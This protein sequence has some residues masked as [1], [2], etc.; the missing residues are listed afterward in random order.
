MLVYSIFYSLGLIF[1]NIALWL[2]LWGMCSNNVIIPWMCNI[3]L[4]FWIEHWF[5]PRTITFQFCSLQV[6]PLLSSPSSTIW[7]T[8]NILL[9]NFQYWKNSDI[10]LCSQYQT[11]QTLRKGYIFCSSVSLCWSAA[12]VRPHWPNQETKLSHSWLG[13]LGDYKSE[14]FSFLLSHRCFWKKLIS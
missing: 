8:E 2:S 9:F 13:A 10:L 11:N 5:P 14:K 3:H 7:K 4:Y 12:L 6:C 1:S